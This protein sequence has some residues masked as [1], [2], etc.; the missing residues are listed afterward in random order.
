LPKDSSHKPEIVPFLQRLLLATAEKLS[1]KEPISYLLISRQEVAPEQ[2]TLAEGLLTESGN[3]GAVFAVD[4]NGPAN[5][6]PGVRPVITESKSGSL[7]RRLAFFSEPEDLPFL[8]APVILLDLWE[9]N[10]AASTVFAYPGMAAERLC[11]AK[12]MLK[13]GCEA[14][15]LRQEDGPAVVIALAR[16]RRN[17]R[18]LAHWVNLLDQ[19]SS[20]PDPQA[21]F[22][23]T[24]AA[25][26][27]DFLCDRVG[28]IR[29][30]PRQPI[31]YP[32]ACL[33]SGP[34]IT[35]LIR[36]AVRHIL[37]ECPELADDPLEHALR[38]LNTASP[39]IA[40]TPGNLIT[41]LMHFIWSSRPDLQSA[42]NLTTSEGRHAFVDWCFSRAPIELDLADDFLI[43]ARRERENP[44]IPVTKPEPVLTTQTKVPAVQDPRTGVNIIGYA[45]AE[46]G[47]GEQMR[48]C[49]AA[50]SATN[51]PFVIRDFPFGLIASQRDT[52]FAGAISIDHPFPI[53]LFHINAAQ[54]S[55]VRQHLGL[56][57]FR[58]HY[59][60]GYW[61]W[62]LSNFPD[63]WQDAIDLMDEIW[64]VSKFTQAAIAQKTSKPVIWMPEAVEFPL[65]VSV[66]LPSLAR[67]KFGLPEAAYLFLF[68]FDFSS[69]AARKNPTGCIHAFQSAFPE[70]NENVGLVI[71]TIRHPHHKR[72]F[73]QLLRDIGDDHRIFLIDCVLRKNEL[74]ELISAC[75]AFVSLHRSEG[76][77]LSIAEAM[78]LGKPVLVTNYSGNTDFTTPNNS[79]LVS[80]RLIPVNPGEYV[81][82]EGQVWAD[83]DLDEA[84]AYMRRLFSEPEYGK[85]LGAA[86]AAHMRR[87]HSYEAIGRRYAKRL[88]QIVAARNV[89][90]SPPE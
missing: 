64:A 81:L 58:D 78:Y 53:N 84:A 51:I 23:R 4:L 67:Q 76:F 28:S 50:L 71:K 37:P 42:F 83:P 88:Q 55:L 2:Q 15:L 66:N 36:D 48:Q 29:A 43:P 14:V 46:M 63:E 24:L 57:F 17:E 19:S 39:A 74:H 10:H 1:T 7:L 73:W 47:L 9:K 77:G 11:L 72:E 69:S 49:A 45:R 6:P 89:L 90:A 30:N 80:Y 59:N 52:R 31:S 32:P 13:Q 22:D 54:M 16:N 68:A 25:Q 65:P 87:F 70:T 82:P 5:F 34:P 79:C 3:E 26:M 33:P 20:D 35:P 18:M 60:I 85:Q 86:A 62:E 40:Q 27:V 21:S 38:C 41:R 56:T 12:H 75:D 61:A 44:S 8:I